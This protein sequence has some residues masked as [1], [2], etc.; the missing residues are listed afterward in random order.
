M[1]CSVFPYCYP[2][3]SSH[4]RHISMCIGNRHPDLVPIP[5]W[6]KHSKR[7]YK[8]RQSF[9]CQP[10]RHPSHILLRHSNFNKSTRESFGKLHYSHAFFQ[11]GAQHYHFLISSGNLNNSFT[12]PLTGR[13][14]FC[15]EY[16]FNQIAHVLSSS[17]NASSACSFVGA[18][19]CHSNPPNPFTPFPG[20][21]FIITAFG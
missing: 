7:S 2:R 10:R 13:L 4:N 5:P 9:Q 18:L 11:I 14:H 17:I 3:M 21:V 19:P 20:V 15:L 12:K 16:I 6:R 1:G 8:R